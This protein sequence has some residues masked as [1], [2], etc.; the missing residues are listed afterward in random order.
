M[1]E[2]FVSVYVFAPC[3]YLMSVEIRR[4]CHTSRTGVTG[5]YKS[6]YGAGGARRENSGKWE[7]CPVTLPCALGSQP[8]SVHQQGSGF[9][10]TG[11]YEG[12]LLYWASDSGNFLCLPGT[13]LRETVISA[14]IK[15]FLS[16]SFLIIVRTMV[17]YKPFSAQWSL[18][19][20][21][22]CFCFYVSVSYIRKNKNKTS[23]G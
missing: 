12:R 22:V 5:G 4:G 15:A 1:C 10:D 13:Q 8:W 21:Y 14:L 3:L 17:P 18:D 7:E 20:K 23:G 2:Y 16:F 19:S 9:P 6:P 11:L